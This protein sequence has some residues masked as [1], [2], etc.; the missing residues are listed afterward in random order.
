[1]QCE[2]NLTLSLPETAAKLAVSD[3]VNSHPLCSNET[4][5]T[6]RA[7]EY[8]LPAIQ[9]G[10]SGQD[11]RDETGVETV[12]QFSHLFRLIDTSCVPQM[13]STP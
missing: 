7:L 3:Q 5:N 11:P 13:L 4:E 12:G 2:E 8:G 1:M 6:M 9:K 10:E